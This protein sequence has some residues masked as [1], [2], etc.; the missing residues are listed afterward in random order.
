ME[1]RQKERNY[2]E[3]QECEELWL[4]AARASLAAAPRGLTGLTG[5]SGA[6]WGGAW[7]GGPPAPPPPPSAPHTPARL[8]PTSVVP[9]PSHAHTSFTSLRGGNT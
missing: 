7:R 9:H 1:G 3:R 5:R 6:A 8:A 2:V 4:P